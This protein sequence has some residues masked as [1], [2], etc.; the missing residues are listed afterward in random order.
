[1]TVLMCQAN[2][3]HAEC[4]EDDLVAGGLQ[5]GWTKCE[6]QPSEKFERSGCDGHTDENETR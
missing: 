5:A 2:D 4:A 3:G 6:G 1:M